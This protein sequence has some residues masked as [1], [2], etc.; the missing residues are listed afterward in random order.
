[1]LGAAA[2]VVG[3]LHPRPLV[4]MPIGFSGGCGVLP[5]LALFG[6]AVPV[7]ATA[8]AVLTALRPAPALRPSPAG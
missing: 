6:W 8:A 5:D 3:D 4:L 1:M 2:A 7:L